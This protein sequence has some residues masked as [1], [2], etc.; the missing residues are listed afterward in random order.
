MEE[1]D[2]V[3]AGDSAAVGIV[4]RFHSDTDLE[5]AG[6]LALQECFKAMRQARGKEGNPGD[7]VA[8]MDLKVHAE[9]LGQRAEMVG[10]LIGGNMESIEMKF[11]AGKE[12]A[13]FQVGVL[14]RLQDVAAVQ[15]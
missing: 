3:A 13:G 12:D 2:A 10:D 15:K 4:L 9:F 1:G 14:I 5:L 7:V 11:E 8:E 6:L